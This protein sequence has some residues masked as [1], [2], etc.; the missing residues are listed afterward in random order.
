MKSQV[1]VM[2][3]LSCAI[4]VS[5]S[6]AGET[7]LIEMID[8]SRQTFAEEALLV[9]QS[10]EVHI[11]AR[12]AMDEKDGNPVAS[13]W[14]L[15]VDSRE[16]VWSL[17]DSKKDRKRGRMDVNAETSIQLDPGKYDVYFSVAPYRRWGSYSGGDIGDFFSR[18]FDGRSKKDWRREARKWGLTVKVDDSDLS[19]LE[20]SE[21][22]VDL[23]NAIT[24]TG[25]GDDEYEEILFKIDSSTKFRVYAIGEGADGEMYDY[26]LILDVETGE[27]VW[28]MAYRKTRWAGGGSKNRKIDETITLEAGSYRMSFVTDDSHSPESWNRLMPYDHLLWGITLWPVEGSDVRIVDEDQ[29]NAPIVN[30]SRVGDDEFRCKGFTLKRRARVRVRCLGELGYKR[31]FADYGWILNARTREKVWALSQPRDSHAGGG[32]KNRMFDGVITLD[33]G[34]YQV[35]YQSDDSHSYNNWNVA[36]PYN[37]SAWGITLWGVDSD[38]NEDWYS[39]FSGGKDPAVLVQF[40]RVSDDRRL[41]DRFTLDKDT[42]VRVYAI[43]EGD[44]DEMYDYGWIED[45]DGEKVWRMSY[46]DSDHAGGARKNRRINSVI[47]L[48]KGEYRVYYKTDGSHSYDSW[49]SAPPEDAEYWGI[50]VRKEN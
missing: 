25:L 44:A 17:T 47:T 8:F 28:E 5:S 24:L 13:A 45:E 12:G 37:P 43:G 33:P 10:V 48:E 49:N 30:I 3:V 21:H 42:D 32:K 15:D 41:R 34:D 1:V 40:I 14:I 36:P 19:K 7:T 26:G 11:Q 31:Y 27:R 38:F 35:C 6:I 18:L 9:K 23:G 2:L 22:Q 16:V 4:I 20:L 50:T 39:S 46:R 29:Q